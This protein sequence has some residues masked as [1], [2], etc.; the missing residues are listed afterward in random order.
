MIES[1][2]FTPAGERDFKRL[3]HQLQNR[4]IEKIGLYISSRNPLHFAKPLVN[5][6]PAT[7]RFRVGKYRI[8]FYIEGL[9]IIIDGV[10][11]RED[12]YRR[13]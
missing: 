4:I 9:N 2:E 5:L 11:T 1:L 8:C 10:D 3:S 13:R 6:P 7:H 12:A